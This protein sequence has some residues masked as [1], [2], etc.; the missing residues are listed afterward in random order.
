MIEAGKT[1]HGLE[2][3]RENTDDYT[4]YPAS[5]IDR[6][7]ETGRREIPGRSEPRLLGYNQWAVGDRASI[8]LAPDPDPNRVWSLVEVLIVEVLGKQLYRVGVEK[9]DGKHQSIAGVSIGDTIDL[10]GSYFF[11]IW[12]NHETRDDGEGPQKIH[13]DG[14]LHRRYK[15]E[16]IKAVLQKKGR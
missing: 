10:P 16:F 13:V 15:P 14:T 2:P 5:L 4:T 9:F 3:F 7:V 11:A 1:H 12:A 6:F 8:H